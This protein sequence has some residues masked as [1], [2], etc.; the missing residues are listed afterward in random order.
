[1]KVVRLQ[2]KAVINQYLQKNKP[3]HIYSIGDLDDFFWEYTTWY[4]WADNDEI[5]AIILLYKGLTVPTLLALSEDIE[6]L[7][8]LLEEIKLILPERMYIHLS[9]GLIDII[10]TNYNVAAYGD[11]YKMSANCLKESDNFDHSLVERI[12]VSELEE[13]N[14]L[15]S[16]SYPGNW[17]D[18]RMLES[19][20]YFGLRQTDRFVSVAGI[21]VYSPLFRVAAIGN[22]ATHPDFRGRGFGK[23]VTTA[24]CRELF[25]TVDQIGLNVKVDNKA[26]IKIYRRLGF[27]VA[28]VYGE[29]MVERK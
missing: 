26:A 12:R 17:F 10:E 8:E 13:L 28:G 22:I 3:L 1:M 20:H 14:Q 7:R 11:H 25:K 5:S 23:L 2:E 4:G 18:S 29:Y 15:F 9:P 27:E 19:G 24:C 21:H 16:E 6:P